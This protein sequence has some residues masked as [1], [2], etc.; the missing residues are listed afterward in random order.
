MPR[1]RKR[2]V[3]DRGERADW[4]DG[5]EGPDRLAAVRALVESLARSLQVP[6][7][8]K[9]DASWRKGRERLLQLQVEMIAERVRE[10]GTAPP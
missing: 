6:R 10:E 5:L 1:A 8:C 4:L 7:E 9:R 2:A 3:G